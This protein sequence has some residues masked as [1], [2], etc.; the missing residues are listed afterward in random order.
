M[1]QPSYALFS[2]FDRLL[3]LTRGGRPVYFGELGTDCRTLIAY[4][5]E[6][7]ARLKTTSIEP[8]LPTGVNPATW[9]LSACVVK[10]ADFASAY[11]LSELAVENEKLTKEAL[12][13]P[14]GYEPPKYDSPY[15]LSVRQQFPY[16]LRRLLISYWRGPSYNV[17]RGEM[18]VLGALLTGGHVGMV[19]IVISL[20]FGSCYP[21]K[22]PEAV[23]SFSR[24]LG[25]VGLFFLATF[26]MGIIFFSSALS[27]MTIERAAYYR[28]KA[29]R[30]YSAYPYTLAFGFAETPYL[31]VFAFLHSSV[32]WGLVDF[33]PGAE[34]FFFYTAYYLLYIAFATFFAQFLVAALPDEVCPLLEI[35]FSAYILGNCGNDWHRGYDTLIAC[36]WFCDH[37]R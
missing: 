25:R 9:M 3:L 14:P 22:R 2:V 36:C 37:A 13:A 32:L 35:S 7:I 30:M 33:Y 29:S 31:V 6:T 19:S 24:V 26:F 12:V 34:R 28:E 1:F 4:L 20:I 27:Q 5:E 16:L 10:D 15:V 8:T 21:R 11:Y 23:D 17:A 18:N